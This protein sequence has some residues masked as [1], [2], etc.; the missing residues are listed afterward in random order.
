M[1]FCYYNDPS[2]KQQQW[3]TFRSHSDPIVKR[4]FDPDKGGEAPTQTR[5]RGQSRERV[6]RPSRRVYL[7]YPD[8]GQ[9]LFR[10]LSLRLERLRRRHRRLSVAG[11]KTRSRFQGFFSPA[12]VQD[13]GNQ[14]HSTFE[15]FAHF[16]WRIRPRLFG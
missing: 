10:S 6:T 9:L 11:R 8:P 3:L 1:C 12:S 13:G 16:S 15:G 2:A 14:A 5:G 4:Q 7:R